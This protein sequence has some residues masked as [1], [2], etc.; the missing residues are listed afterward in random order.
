MPVECWL[1]NNPSGLDWLLRKIDFDVF[2]LQLQSPENEKQILA[3]INTQAQ[4]PRAPEFQ[5][6]NSNLLGSS[7]ISGREPHHILT[8]YEKTTIEIGNKIF[9]ISSHYFVRLSGVA[10]AEVKITWKSEEPSRKKTELNCSPFFHVA[11]LQSSPSAW[12]G[13]VCLYDAT[14]IRNSTNTYSSR[15]YIRMYVRDN[16]H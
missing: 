6:E 2:V 1:T 4:V 13:F 15:V 12:P 5:L 9:I 11:A 8:S 10:A 7:R 3:Q 16:K 14:A